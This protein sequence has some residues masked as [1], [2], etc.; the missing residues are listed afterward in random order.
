ME[1]ETLIQAAERT[2]SDCFGSS[3]EVNFFSTAPTVVHSYNYPKKIQ[4]NAKKGARMF[5]FKS[6][7]K[8]GS[9]D[10]KKVRKELI[11]DYSW[12]TRDEARELM[13]E[14]NQEKFWKS[15]SSSF[16]DEVMSEETIKRV[17]SQVRRNVTRERD[18]NVAIEIKK[19]N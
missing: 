15:L 11:Q 17:L 19:Q 6:F 8:S 3:L 7:V 14:E 12:L 16:L 10:E 4:S 18:A 9:I 1:S 2:I 13:V 5:I